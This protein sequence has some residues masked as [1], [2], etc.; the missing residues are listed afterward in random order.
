MAEI[1]GLYPMNPREY[2]PAVLEAMEAKRYMRPEYPPAVLE[3]MAAS[4]ASRPYQPS[5]SWFKRT[6]TEPYQPEY[7]PAVLERLSARPAFMTEAP[8]H[9]QSPQTEY[10][11]AAL[12]RLGEGGMSNMS[13]EQVAQILKKQEMMEQFKQMI[14][15]RRHAAMNP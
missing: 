13:P 7:P 1:D 15:A 4:P 8:P 6:F 3:R 5:M 12:E 10:P 14:T 9:M 11:P 2:P